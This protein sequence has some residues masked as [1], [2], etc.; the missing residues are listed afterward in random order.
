MEKVADEL[1]ASHGVNP[2][3]Y[4]QLKS[5][6]KN[7]KARTKSVIAKDRRERTK[8]GEVKLKEN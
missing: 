8:T 6:W 7:M 1:N 3:K 4:I 5:L 2:R